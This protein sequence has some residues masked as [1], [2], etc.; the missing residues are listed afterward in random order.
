V[1]Y[2]RLDLRNLVR[3][4]V[5]DTS[6]SPVFADTQIN[7]E[8]AAAFADYSQFFPNPTSVSLTSTAGQAAVLLGAGVV[9][10]GA[11]IV[12]GVAV[13]EVPDQQTLYEPAFRNQVSQT[14]VQPVTPFGAAA[15]HGQAWAYFNQ[16]VNFR[17]GLSVGRAV[18]IYSTLYHTLPSDD[19]TAV[20]VPDND[21]ELIALYACDRLSRSAAFDAIKRG[22][23][24]AW[25]E[26]KGGIGWYAD[27]YRQKLR[28]RRNRLVS[29]TVTVLQ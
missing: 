27:Q 4:E 21:V 7:D 16:S 26:G 18:T 29:R 25:V 10:V 5:M 23:P 12:D 9:A 15:T 8:L 2:T 13:P 17:Y 19:V 24:G 3:R 14:I 6:G 22:A 1:A 28:D 11:V 20:T